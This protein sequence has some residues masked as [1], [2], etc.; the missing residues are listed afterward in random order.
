MRISRKRARRLAAEREKEAE[1]AREAAARAK[2]ARRIALTTAFSAACL[3]RLLGTASAA[4]HDPMHDI[5]G[6]LNDLRDQRDE[7]RAYHETAANLRAARAALAAAKQDLADAKQSVIDA[8]QAVEEAKKD[9]AASQTALAEAQEALKQA[10][11]ISAEK[12][13]AAIAAQQ[14][15]Y[16]Y[17]QEVA[18]RQAAVDE[19]AAEQSNAEAQAEA[20]GAVSM[21][22]GN[23]Y[24]M[25]ANREAAVQKALAEVGYEQNRLAEA[26]R[27]ADEYTNG[28]AA[29][30]DATIAAAEAAQ[31]EA[32]AWSARVDEI[33]AALDDAEDALDEAQ[34]YL[35][36]LEDAREEAEEEEADA[37]ADEREAEADEAQAETDV[38]E[39]ETN[40]AQ[41]ENDQQ[42]AET[43]V[44]E[45][46]SDVAE[47]TKDEGELAHDLFHFGEGA[48]VQTGVEYAHAHAHQLYFPLSIYKTVRLDT[49]PGQEHVHADEWPG[50]EARHILDFSLST[51]WLDSSIGTENG[52]SAGMTDT[53]LSARYHNDHPVNSMRYGLAINLPTG[54]NRFYQNAIVPKGL[55]LFED[56][57]K[58]WEY[59]PSV[60]A[61]HHVT[62]RDSLIARFA[63]TFRKKYR[64][65]K[66][67]SE[68]ETNPGDIADLELSYQHIGE[69][70]QLRTWM[71]LSDT[72]KTTQ[73]SVVK[74]D[75]GQ[76]GIEAPKTH[77]REGT[78]IELGVAA[79]WRVGPKDELGVFGTYGHAM[80][81]HGI[82][83][84]ATDDF[85]L[86]VGLR[87][88][89]TPRLSWE[90][91]ASVYHSTTGYNALYIDE[92]TNNEPWTRWSLLGVL[93]YRM[94]DR[95]RLTLNI[96][97]YIRSGLENHP[98]QG[99]AVALW[100]TRSF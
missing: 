100:Y 47:A 87:H 49:Y 97:R 14:A 26:I 77:Y 59:T 90:A 40:L 82:A 29:I 55:G 81:V 98:Y 64:L 75:A 71:T 24:R 58:G 9:L 13:Q 88:A 32:D 52:H 73:D 91:L 62:E 66:E 53:T 84:D 43:W 45:A 37:R 36:A 8:K 89:M 17:Q 3:A 86:A 7:L 39:S 5:A 44:S 22:A 28:D 95:E 94:T 15:A 76:W 60:E 57:G 30:D 85:E 42:S 2:I 18:A 54:Q 93:D 70:H 46:E 11:A 72:A 56:F 6:E 4:Y 65:S 31:D 41:A 19:L 35:E 61:V 33:T 63:Y 23:A 27:L 25:Y 99:C 67:V 80:R 96:E 38:K 78:E 48:G 1:R 21:R 50:G 34:S 10:R 69:S 79:S 83:G 92:G 16:D 51:G 20:A 74:N 68:A 12:T